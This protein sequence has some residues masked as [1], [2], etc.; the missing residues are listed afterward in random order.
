MATFEDFQKLDIRVGKIIYVEDFPEA[1]KPAYKLTID[2]G[3]EIGIKKSSVQIVKNYKKEDLKEKL[4]LCVVNFPPRQ[5]GQV[6]SEVLTLGVPD[7]NKE[8]LL[9]K[10]DK[11]APVGVKLY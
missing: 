11:D 10:P 9:I 4:V 5:I 7:K 6:L 8:C 1:K 2:F 3:N